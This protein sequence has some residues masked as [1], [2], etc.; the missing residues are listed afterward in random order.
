MP[1]GRHG[2][3]VLWAFDVWMEVN[4][5]L[6]GFVFITLYIKAFCE[7]LQPNVCVCVCVRAYALQ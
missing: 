2:R 6:N 1:A 5:R 4:N 7:F 3:E